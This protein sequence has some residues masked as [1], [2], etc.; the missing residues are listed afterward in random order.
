MRGNPIDLEEKLRH[1]T[2]LR[3][4]EEHKNKMQREI[5][6]E[7]MQ[8]P[9]KHGGHLPPSLPHLIIGMKMSAWYTTN[10]RNM[11]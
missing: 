4:N 2:S 1:N 7:L 8:N 9:Y 5:F 10:L 3:E 6:I 11:K